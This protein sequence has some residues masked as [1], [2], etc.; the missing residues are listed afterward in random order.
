[1]A[2]KFVQDLS[3]P[4]TISGLRADEIVHAT[5][6][7]RQALVSV[8][9]P[10]SGP[11][12][13]PEDVR[14]VLQLSEREPGVYNV[15]VELIAPK[16]EI[17]SLSPAS[18]TLQIERVEERGLPIVARY[19]GQPRT[20]VDRISF[21]PSI[22]TLR[23]STS[24]FALVQGVRVDVPLPA[25]KGRLDAMARPVAVDARGNELPIAISPNLVRVRATFSA[26]RKK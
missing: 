10:R 17:K 18:V 16:L 7:N 22:A 5:D 26:Q 25:A 8:I 13:R 21:E 12:I 4:I 11:A 20:V 1:V 6:S 15:P 9:V 3:V 23:A 19:V 2:A 14:A 24:R